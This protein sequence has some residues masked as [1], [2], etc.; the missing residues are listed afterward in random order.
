MLGISC[1][2]SARTHILKALIRELE[3]GEINWKV[4]DA[5]ELSDEHISLSEESE[6]RTMPLAIQCS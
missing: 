5:R 2:R 6:A 3:A 1:T 4:F